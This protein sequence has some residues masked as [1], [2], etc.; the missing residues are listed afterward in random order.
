MIL[1]LTNGMELKISIR[2]GELSRD[3]KYP[4]VIGDYSDFFARFEII[5]WTFYFVWC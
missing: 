1:L 4:F 5:L 3:E 2:S